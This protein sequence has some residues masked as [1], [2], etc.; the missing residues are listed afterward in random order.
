MNYF[1]KHVLTGSGTGKIKIK[2]VLMRKGNTKLALYGLG[3]IRDARLHQMFSVKGNVEWARPEDK[4]GF[5][6]KSWFNTMLIHQNR[7][8]HSPKNAISERYLPSWLDL[9]VWGHEHECLVEPTEYGDFMVSQ[10]GSS[11]VT[12]LIEGEAKQKQVFILEV[13]A[14]KNA[15]DDA[16][17]WRAVP[18][19]LET[20]RPFKYRQISLIDFARLAKEDGGLG[21]D[22]TPESGET[23]TGL[24]AKGK[25]AQPSKHEAWIT[26]ALER[27]VRELIAEARAPYE[28]RGEDEVPLPLIRLRVDYGGFSTINAQRF[29]Q[30]FVGKV[31]NP[32]DLLQFFKSAARRRREDA[33]DAA[34]AAAAHTTAVE[35]IIGNPTMQDQARIEQ[36]VAQHLTQGLQLLSEADLS[37]A[38]DDF[39]NRDKSALENLIKDRLRETMKFVEENAGHEAEMITSG[40]AKDVTANVEKSIAEAVQQRLA[41]TGATAR[42]AAEA[43]AAAGAA[44]AAAA[45][46]P[47]R[48]AAQ[49]K[50]I[51]E[52]A[53]RRA[54]A[55]EEED[56]D[57]DDD[58][59]TIAPS[60]QPGS[61]ADAFR[62]IFNTQA[63]RG[64]RA[65]RGGR[66]GRGAAR[67]GRGSR[68][69]AAAAKKR[70]AAEAFVVEDGEGEEEDPDSG[71]D[72]EEIPATRPSRPSRAAA[73]VGAAASPGEVDIVPESDVDDDDDDEVPASRPVRARGRP[74]RAAAAVRRTRAKAADNS[75]DAFDFTE[76]TDDD[77][78]DEVVEES[79]DDGE[80]EEEEE[81]IAVVG[82]RGAKR[83]APAKAAA[84]SAKR[85]R[86]G[87]GAAKKAPPRGK[88]SP[89][90]KAPPGRT[91]A[92]RAVHIP[93]TQDEDS[94]ED[95]E[96][97][98]ATATRR[99]TRAR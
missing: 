98:P 75:P 72:E 6:S 1:G 39:V 48:A 14:D 2:P 25:R 43:E 56:G 37:N 35:D 93:Y 23:N 10:P 8:H 59:G 9:V 4:P 70:A 86:A 65:G 41:R 90:A 62:D 12:S 87:G 44:T 22:F 31:A 24:G 92:K 68:A 3:Y 63:S 83:K 47:R 55:A 73:A 82:R 84:T 60:E 32:N 85:T 97:I 27:M 15:P 57:G 28:R 20:V 45:T 80:D 26:Q 52:H 91:R 42:A 21:A 61:A 16:P 51:I 71:V 64:A 96:E 49:E 94:G 36:L 33:N 11:V 89:P 66:A 38:L 53:R 46:T 29:G 81:A 78:D 54:A 88:K 77:D 19:P 18:Q 95:D 79:G 76:D 34:T 50:E 7:V 67:G 58:L 69:S 17:M 13:K 40:D 5:S 99:S 30:K 74:T